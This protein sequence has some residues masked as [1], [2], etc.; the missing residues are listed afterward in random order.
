MRQKAFQ[1]GSQSRN[2]GMGSSAMSSMVTDCMPARRWSTGRITTRGSSWRIVTS[3]WSVEKGSAQTTAS[4]RWSS[5]AS[6][7]LVPAQVHGLH[8]GV[9]VLATQRTHRRGDD[10][11]CCVADGDAAGLGGVAGL[12]YGLGGRA[13]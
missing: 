12:R 11:A 5:S 7:W 10:H 9:G 1:A 6:R 2:F 4:T 3:R 13:Q 8:V